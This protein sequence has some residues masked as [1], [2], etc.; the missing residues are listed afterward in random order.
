MI[1]SRPYES[2]LVNI[3]EIYCESIVVAVNFSLFIFLS[4]YENKDEAGAVLILLIISAIVAYMIVIIRAF[5]QK[6]I[7]K[8]TK[9]R[10]PKV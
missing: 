6:V 10:K 5:A 4:D 8:C 9:R 1:T 7:E 2:P 3:I